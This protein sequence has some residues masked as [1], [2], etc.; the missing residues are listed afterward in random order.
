MNQAEL[1][2]ALSDLP[3]GD[4]RYYESITSTNDYAADWI[5]QAPPDLSL[6]V[7]DEQTRGRGR[8]GRRWF[9]P[10]NSALAFSLVIYPTN[11]YRR[12]KLTLYTGLGALAVTQTLERN[13]NLKPKIKWP[14]DVLLEG[15]KVCGILVESH[16]QGDQLLALILGIG[17]NIAPSSVPQE[18]L[19]Y[20]A[21]SVE[22]ILG[23]ST[24]RINFL[25]GVLENIVDWRKRINS[26][27][28]ITAWEQRL[29]FRGQSMRITLE[30]QAS[31]QAEIMGLDSLGK[32]KLQLISGEEII[33][34]AGEIQ[35]QPLVDSSSI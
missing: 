13:F 30:G 23:K 10:P 2:N 11:E 24:D 25:K 1:Q 12:S 32:L 7:A 21:T 22:D 26:L 17:I 34:Q 15:K 3:L 19:T 8:S 35:I 31:M 14:N 16:W 18:T 6:V 20:S 5:N 9:T 29:A 33:V 27:E 4:I 28:F